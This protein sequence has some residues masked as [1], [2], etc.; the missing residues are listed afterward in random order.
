[1]KKKNASDAKKIG[2]AAGGAFSWEPLHMETLKNGLTVV[3]KENHAAPLAVTDVWFKVGSRNE[4]DANNGVAHFL[5]HTLFKGTEKRG[6][7]EIAKDIE[8]FGGRTN[9]G[10]SMDFTHYYISCESRHIFK[11]LDIHADVFRS[12]TLA[13]EAI[14]Q[15]RQVIIEE[16]K[17]GQDSPSKVMWDMM[18]SNLFR[19]HPYHRLVLG[20][21]ENIAG[22]IKRDDM[23]HFFNKWYSPGN[24][25]LIVVGDVDAKAVLA[26]V[27]NLY[28][29]LASKAP[30]HPSFKSEK[31]LTKPQMLR[32]EM[33]VTRGY[34]L[35]TWRTVKSASHDDLMALDL[36]GTIL[37]QGRTSRLSLSLKESRSLVTSVSAGQLALLDDGFFLVRA[38]YDPRDEREV[39]DG[40]KKEIRLLQESLVPE[41][42]L[43]KAKD[44][45]ENWG[46]RQ[47]ETNEGKAEALGSA[48]V[49]GEWKFEKDYFSHISRVTAKHIREAA[50]KYLVEDSSV[51]VFVSPKATASLQGETADMQKYVLANG[52]RVIHRP[53]PGSGL[54]GV[55]LAIDAGNRRE[56]PEKSG[57]SNLMSDMLMKGT[58]KRDGRQIL[59]DLE[60]LGSELSPNAEPDV[61]R[62][63]LSSSVRK[64]SAAFEIL[65]DVIRCPTF[66]AE[67][68]ADEK[69][70]V[71]MR[72]KAV[73]DDM[74]EN[75]WTLFLR[76]LYPD[77]PY[78]IHSLG[79]VEEVESLTIPD[80]AEF[81]RKWCVPENMVMAIV[82][83]IAAPAALEVVSRFFGTMASTTPMGLPG[84]SSGGAGN[85][86]GEIKNP[87]SAF[88]RVDDR[89][90]KAQSMMCLG[91]LGPSISHPDY[92]AMKV[93]NSVLGGGMSSRYFMNIRTRASLAYMTTGVYPSR[94]DQAPV[95]AVVGTDPKKVDQ[96]KDLVLKE[97]SDISANGVSNEELE[98]SITYMTGQFALDHSSCLRIA[99]YLSWF[100][101]IGVGFAFDRDFPEKLRSVTAD[102][103]RRVAATWLK[104]EQALMAVTGPA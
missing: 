60:S 66:P 42:E 27:K 37:G 53:L 10:T 96:A 102:D 13:A 43:Q 36:L 6:I 50:R 11:A 99:H 72:L 71:L 48:L 24:M 80:L 86:L 44:L 22:G 82:G 40:I 19:K 2:A 14:D 64:F 28:G 79:R 73:S 76:Q 49:R 30:K 31:R 95:C 77:H 75:T 4:D 20:P 46:I 26:K 100:E 98:R 35:N 5:E 55:S 1:M 57:V 16:I 62:F 78:G 58:K 52:L 9:A 8:S 83:D 61:L 54:I 3:V 97:I 92:A 103:L 85:P 25:T 33:D 47:L 68:F 38:E 39:L 15:E 90:E 93:L 7:G 17:R 18:I 29:D 89:K 63:N 34:Y 45:T 32:H 67:A 91:W 101:S 87:I 12:S 59:W 81:H 94:I 23:V 104:P 84:V 69:N 70:K 56:I 88:T 41:A 74:F 21:E 51:S 65:A